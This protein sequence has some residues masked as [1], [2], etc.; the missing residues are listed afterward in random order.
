MFWLVS[1]RPGAGK[2][3]FAARLATD[4]ASQGRKVVAN[5]PI[6]FDGLSSRREGRLN[7]ARPVI[8][9]GIPTRDQL[10]SIGQGG[11]RE[12]T[13]G[14]LI[15]DEVGVSLGSRSWA[16]KEREG[17]LGWF[18]EHR[19]R[20]WDVCIICQHVNQID[21]QL[22][23]SFADSFVNVR[24]LDRVKL[25]GL[26]KLPKVHLA[27]GKYGLEP[28]APVNERWLMRGPTY[29]SVYDS[30]SVVAQ[31]GDSG[32]YSALSRWDLVDRYKQPVTLLSALR[33]VGRWFLRFVAY[34]YITALVM[35][36]GRS[37]VA[38]ATAANISLRKHPPC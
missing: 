27:I 8:L 9:D 20:R 37:P 17:I 36:T 30:Y 4:Y 22:R 32:P 23:V 2:S 21:K 25:L 13:A 34:G 29:Y 33:S 26:L 31:V 3:L 19:K 12:E 14:L 10:D 7:K 28:G 16:D 24:R 1:G 6:A 15:L 11:E 5:F 35:A 18:A 38:I